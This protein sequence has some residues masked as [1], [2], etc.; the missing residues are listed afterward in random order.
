[1]IKLSHAKVGIAYQVEGIDLPQDHQKHLAHLGI[2][3]GSQVKVMS[4]P[5][6]VRL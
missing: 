1:M 2:T 3:K 5:N 4:Q 6:R